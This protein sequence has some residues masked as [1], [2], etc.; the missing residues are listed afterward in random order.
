MMSFT[1]FFTSLSPAIVAKYGFYLGFGTSTAMSFLALFTADSLTIRANPVFKHTFSK[2]SADPTVIKALGDGIISGNLRSYRLDSGKFEATSGTALTWRNPRIQ[3]I[4]DVSGQGPPFRTGIVTCE[5]VKV[6]G[7]FPPK[8]RT[9]ILKVDYE[10]GNEG[11]GGDV[12]G[13]QTIWIRG[14][15][16][17]YNRVSARSGLSLRGLGAAMHINKAAV[18]K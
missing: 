18:G 7:A 4:F 11:E 6:T 3:M 15:E 16:E 1:H 9:N 8:L 13:D 2:V 12:E 14:D 5:A 17:K 10:D